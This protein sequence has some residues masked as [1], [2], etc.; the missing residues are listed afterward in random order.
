M[1]S[2]TLLPSDRKSA[3]PTAFT[4][5]ELLVVIAIIG[6]LASMLLPALSQAK[7]KATGAV[8]MGNMKQLALAWRMYPDDY[9]GRLAPNA[10]SP[11]AGSSTACPSWVRGWVTLGNVSDNTNTDNLVD[12]ARINDAYGNIGNYVGN[13]KVYKCPADRSKDTGTGQARVRTISMNGWVQPGGVGP[14]A[15]AC[16][17]GGGLSTAY[18]IYR[19]ATDFVKKK[20]E[21]I[22]VF[23]DEREDSINDGWFWVSEAGYTASPSTN[24]YQIIDWPGSYHTKSTSF[25]FADGHAEMHRWTD[26]RTMPLVQNGAYVSNPGM[27]GNLDIQWLQE[28]STSY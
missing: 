28:H 27:A 16:G 17:A 14:P 19:R 7:T 4:L 25:S 6:I 1:N 5:I 26:S 12:P 22:W 24:L 20:P 18:E 3:G 13:P 2:P 8:C 10:D 23:L 15:G 9:D 11:S 21:D